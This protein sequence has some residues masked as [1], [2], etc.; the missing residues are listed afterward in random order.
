MKP[1]AF[2]IAVAL[3][4]GL[5]GCAVGPDYH[6]PAALPNQ[7]LPDTF[8]DGNPANQ[9]V[10]KIAEPSADQPRG[11]WWQLFNDPELNGL[12]SLL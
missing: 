1:V 8:S 12:K 10:W 3:A 5:A 9:A 7:P 11:N 4:S 2:I 6:R